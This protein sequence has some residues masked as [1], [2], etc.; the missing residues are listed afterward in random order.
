M[1]LMKMLNRA[2]AEGILP[3]HN[4]LKL[5]TSENIFNAKQWVT[6]LNKVLQ[7]NYIISSCSERYNQ[8]NMTRKINSK[9]KYHF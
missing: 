5:M 1:L 3:L 7:V 8:H 4:K 6:K 9:D 2:D